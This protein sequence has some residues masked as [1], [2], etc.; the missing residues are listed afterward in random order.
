MNHA[1]AQSGHFARVLF[2]AN[3]PDGQADYA[4]RFEEALR[5][6]GHAVCVVHQREYES[7]SQSLA[8]SI[9][10]FQPTL[11]LWDAATV[12]MDDS[13]VPALAETPCFHVLFRTPFEMPCPPAFDA[14][15]AVGSRDA[16]SSAAASST[17]FISPAP[18]SAYQT[19]ILSDKEISRK[20]TL[21][22]QQLTAEQRA[23]V[24]DA[25][26]AHEDLAPVSWKTYGMNEAFQARSVKTCVYFANSEPGSPDASPCPRI[27]A[28]ELCMRIAEGALVCVEEGA[29]DCLD[30]QAPE[31]R[32]TLVTFCHE[33]FIPTME[34]VLENEEAYRDA[35]EKQRRALDDLE[36]LERSI[37]RVLKELNE[38]ARASGCEPVLSGAHP[39]LSAVLYGWY[40]ADN[41]GD[42]L[43]MRLIADR[44]ERRFPQREIHIAG[45]RPWAIRQRFGYEA[46]DLR[47]K[48]D[49][50]QIFSHAALLCFSG[51]LLFDQPMAET[52]GEA[53]FLLDPFMEPSCQASTALM[54]QMLGASPVGIGLGAGPLDNPATRHMVYLMGLARMR[55]IMRDE[56]SAALIRESGVSGEQVEVAADLAFG[57]RLFIKQHAQS[58]DYAC[59]RVPY[60]I[61]ALRDFHLNPPD[62]E[63]RVAQT[64]DTITQQT[65]LP[66]LFLP[67]DATDTAIHRRVQGLL[68]HP[69]K[70]VLIEEK[71]SMD[72]FMKLIDES[73]FSL[74]MRLHCSILHHVMGKPA[75]GI[76]YNDKVQ[77]HFEE[78]GLADCLV[79]MD[80]SAEEMASRSLFCI[81]NK[82]AI[83]EQIRPILEEKAQRVDAAFEELFAI[84]EEAQAKKHGAAEYEAAKHGAAKHG[85]AEYG[86]VKCEA[87]KHGAAKRADP[88]VFYPRLVSPAALEAH[89]LKEEVE[90]LSRED[91]LRAGESPS[92]TTR[93][94]GILRR[95]RSRQAQ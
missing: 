37:A 15:L 42:D 10:A 93:G 13:A 29:C 38:A 62:F 64:I 47:D 7:F 2:V 59:P 11:L 63:S 32:K 19:A 48:N 57:A 95:L 51:G 68:K 41:F 5:S 92:R 33:T 69:E 23:L 16:E 1:Q 21:Y 55:F 12:P 60:F 50:H 30:E 39:A 14:C 9:S 49:L 45:Y 28:V 34:S 31:L 72:A 35:L 70:S 43:L 84:A 54:A 65:G 89:R 88:L 44:I 61:V 85:A 22:P 40:G 3:Y 20:G 81:A 46:V 71:P 87:K 76:N 66:A 4:V 25:A 27:S 73:S 79:S 18:D 52:A 36:P 26:Q 77:S 6:A 86:A 78:L 75:V 24:R 82:D 67:F 83:A 91:E 80:G 74:A 53:E 90:R 58:S 56:H 94:R 17:M 8:A